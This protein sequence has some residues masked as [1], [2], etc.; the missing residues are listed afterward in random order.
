MCGAIEI[1]SY[2]IYHKCMEDSAS[3]RNEYW[4][5]FLEVN[6]AGAYG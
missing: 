2:F 6:A 4:E 1:K 5:Y 3:N